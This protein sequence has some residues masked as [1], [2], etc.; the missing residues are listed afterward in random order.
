MT[1]RGGIYVGY[2]FEAG[3]VNTIRDDTST[4]LKT[5]AHTV[6]MGFRF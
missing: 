5:R 6:N 3:L 2:D 4:P 1:F